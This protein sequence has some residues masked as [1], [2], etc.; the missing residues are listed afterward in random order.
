MTV[1]SAVG[2]DVYQ[3]AEE[4]IES[5]NDAATFCRLLQR[6]EINKNNSNS[7]NS[8]L[9][10]LPLKYLG[11]FAEDV[12][13]KF[14]LVRVLVENVALVYQKTTTAGSDKEREGLDELLRSVLH[15]CK[16]V[17]WSPYDYVVLAESEVLCDQYPAIMVATLQHGLYRKKQ[18]SQFWMHDAH[19]VDLTDTAMLE[20]QRKQMNA[21]D[22]EA[23]LTKTI[24]H[25]RSKY[26]LPE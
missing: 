13:P 10:D 8:I 26:G 21:D 6:H 12:A 19:D 18:S 5:C 25:L 2:E 24:E 20:S 23:A 9:I 4:C 15:V 11:N 3:L 16:E 1:Q 17:L 14:Q 22:S 7:N